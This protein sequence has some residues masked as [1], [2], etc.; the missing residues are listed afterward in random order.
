MG[1]PANSPQCE[2]SKFPSVHRTRIPR[3]CPWPLQPFDYCLTIVWLSFDRFYN[4]LPTACLRLPT[5]CQNHLNRLFDYRLTVFTTACRL[6]AYCLPVFIAANHRDA[7]RANSP[8]P[9]GCNS[10]SGCG[11]RPLLTTVWLLFDHCLTIVW[12]SFKTT[13]S[14]PFHHRFTRPFL[15]Q[16]HHCTGQFLAKTHTLSYTIDI[17]YT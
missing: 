13:A 1:L 14:L 9:K 17:L 4:C 11:L 15:S 12:P 3:P 2:A 7:K 16:L 10:P 5:A 6:L 8:Q